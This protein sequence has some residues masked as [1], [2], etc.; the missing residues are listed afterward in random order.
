MNIA[1]LI[2]ALQGGRDPNQAIVNQFQPGPAEAGPVIPPAY[3]G[4]SPMLPPIPYLGGAS[5]TPGA[6]AYASAGPAMP[7]PA[8]LGADVPP[9]EPLTPPGPPPVAPPAAAPTTAPPPAATTPQGAVT[10][11]T[12][13]STPSTTPAALKS[14]PDLT[15]M[16]IE[17]MK[18]N[19]NAAALDSGLTLMAAGLSNSQATR[20]ALINMA[21]GGGGKGAGGVSSADLINLQKQDQENQNRL[22]RQSMLGGLM[23]EYKLSPETA[24]YLEASGKL[25]EVIKHKNTQNLLEVTH[26]DGSKAFYNHATGQKIVD[27]SP[28]KQETQV[29]EG[30][31]GPELRRT[32]PQ[33]EFAPIGGPVGAKPE[34]DIIERADGSK[35]QRNKRTG[36]TVEVAP[37]RK[38]GDTIPTDVNELE[39]ANRERVAKGL[40]PYSLEEWKK[41][42]PKGTSIYIS[43]DGTTFRPPEPGYEYERNKDGSVYIGPDGRPVQYQIKGGGPDVKAGEDA[44]KKAEKEETAAIAKGEKAINDIF[45]ASNIGNAVKDAIELAPKWGATGYLSYGARALPIGD[46]D[47]LRLDAKLKTIDANVAF[48]TLKQMREASKTGASGL[49]QVTQT[50]H[51]ML[52][53]VIANL[54]P[55]QGEKEL[56]KGLIRVEVAMRLL[57]TND[58]GAKTD[59]MGAQIRFEQAL[60]RGTEQRLLEIHNKKGGSKIERI[61]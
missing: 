15:N 18:K 5:N 47:A 31:Q 56:V 20:S 37:P 51:E 30:P 35:Y 33:G 8:P 46:T 19:Q 16:Y 38:P 25:D 4:G 29:V 32:D 49:G 17:L 41:I 58:F 42:D 21:S 40:P 50:E 14:P 1:D 7:P 52:K 44:A 48:E 3:G 22:L 43:K 34:F 27:I 11:V 9:T 55:H 6:S 57:A 13:P 10:P 26:G 59:P 28:P 54:S 36:E 61:D 45:T 24:Q 2:A 39:F 23:K 12:N 60:N 53:S